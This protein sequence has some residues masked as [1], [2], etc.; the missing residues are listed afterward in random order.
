MNNIAKSSIKY[1]QIVCLLEVISVSVPQEIRKTMSDV[2]D[3]LKLS[4]ENGHANKPVRNSVLL[5]PIVSQAS[6][7]RGRSSSR[8]ISDMKKDSL[9]LDE[10]GEKAPP[11]AMELAAD[12]VCMAAL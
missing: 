1:A 4:P 10:I 12:L 7:T 5:T 3:L 11:P 8:S 2:A 6:S 9:S